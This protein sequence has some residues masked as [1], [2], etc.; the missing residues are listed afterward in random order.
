MPMNEQ[1]RLAQVG[2]VISSLFDRAVC[3]GTTDPRKPQPEPLG[4]EAA[5]LAHALEARKREFAAGR[6][7]A[8]QALAQLGIAPVPVFAAKDR[9]PVWPQ[10]VYGSISHT[11]TLCAAVVADRGHTVGLDLEADTDLNEGLLSTICSTAE[12]AR[13]AGPN[14]LHLG[15]LIFCA[16]EA[17]Y[18]AQYPLTGMLLGFDHI[19]ILLDQAEERF[20]ATFLKPAGCFAAGDRLP[21]RYATVAGHLVTAVWSDKG[22]RKG[23]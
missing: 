17:V 1:D 4:D 8:R 16:K 18:K 19:D 23:A 6:V 15:K 22:M 11:K 13:I 2:A 21:G 12:Q 7:A 10:G 5:H 3:V 14:L 20:S 9:A